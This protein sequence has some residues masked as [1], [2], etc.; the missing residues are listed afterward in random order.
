MA[1]VGVAT[2]VAGTFAMLLLSDL[3]LSVLL[4][5]V[6]S[7]FGTVGLSTGITAGLHDGAKGIL[8]VL[9]F[10]GRVGP[11]TFGAAVVLRERR[12]LFRYPEER[13]ILG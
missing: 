2:V 1:L 5:E 11:T 8:I 6:F 4:F 9:M 10:L 13:T 7:A 3:P 12:R